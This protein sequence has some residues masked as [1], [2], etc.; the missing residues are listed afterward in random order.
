MQK[1]TREGEH[2]LERLFLSE[3][4]GTELDDFDDDVAA[5]NEV[6]DDVKHSSNPKSRNVPITLD[7]I[8]KA[9]PLTIQERIRLRQE[10]LK[11]CDPLI[12]NV[13]T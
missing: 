7:P 5:D 6:E 11:K 2:D 9:Q 10:A 12:I 8:F 13:G 1:Y 4:M 3:A